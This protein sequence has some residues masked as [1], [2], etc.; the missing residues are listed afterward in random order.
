MVLGTNRPFSLF[1]DAGNGGF[2]YLL[3]LHNVRDAV[4]ILLGLVFESFLALLS[5][6]LLLK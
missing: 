2:G 1:L 6:L 4:H 3:E 5:D